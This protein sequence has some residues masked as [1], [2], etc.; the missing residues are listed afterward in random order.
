MIFRFECLREW[1]INIA[2]LKTK[3]S[4]PRFSALQRPFPFS[5]YRYVSDYERARHAR[6]RFQRPVIPSLY[7]RDVKNVSLCA[8]ACYAT[9]D[10]SVQATRLREL[11]AETAVRQEIEFVNVLMRRFSRASARRARRLLVKPP[12]IQLEE[13]FS[14]LFDR[15]CLR[16]Y[17]HRRTAT[18]KLRR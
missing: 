2:T 15:F 10:T 4:P 7:L 13:T 1:T 14:P 18:H 8:S 5:C 12:S 17:C 16:L 9:R 3:S 11:Y 6:A